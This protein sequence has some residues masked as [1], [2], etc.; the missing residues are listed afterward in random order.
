TIANGTF[1][2]SGGVLDIAGFALG[3]EVVTISGSGIGGTGA[4]INSGN[5]LNQPAAIK[6]LILAGNAT[7]GTTNATAASQIGIQNG[8]VQGNGNTLTFNNPGAAG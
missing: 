7:I 1:V 3:Q 6:N 2:Q 5:A 4:L 8:F